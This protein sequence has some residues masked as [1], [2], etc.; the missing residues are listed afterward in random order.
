MKKKNGLKTKQVILSCSEKKEKEEEKRRKK[1]RKE[2]D[3]GVSYLTN[4][5]NQTGISS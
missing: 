4:D 3:E 5:K 2:N 1:K